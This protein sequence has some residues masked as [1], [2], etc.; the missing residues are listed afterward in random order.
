MDADDSVESVEDLRW[1]KGSDGIRKVGKTEGG[2]GRLLRKDMPVVLFRLLD[3][4][5]FM[6]SHRGTKRDYDLD[7]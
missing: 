7:I 4:G 5:E 2:S 1:R 3:C 6:Q